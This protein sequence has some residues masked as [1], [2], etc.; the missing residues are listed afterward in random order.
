MSN[1]WQE[2][3]EF[4]IKGNV[5]DLAIGIIIGAAFNPIVN[6][7]VTDIIM[8]PVGLLLGNVDFSD[9]FILLRSG[10]EAPGPYASL[11]DA[12]AVGAVTIN[13]GLFINTIISFLITAFAVFLLVKL[14][15]RLRREEKEVPPEEPTKDCPYCQSTISAKAIR[16]AYCT[17]ELP[18]PA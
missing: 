17:S 10:P 3:K 11:A 15:N 6:S 7:L 8:P 12:Q 14:I 13:Y 16:C 5:I 2:F 4:A 18:Q 9:L 1:I